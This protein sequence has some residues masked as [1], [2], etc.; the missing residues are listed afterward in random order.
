[1]KARSAD[2]QDEVQEMDDQ[3]HENPKE[4]KPQYIDKARGDDRQASAAPA[5][6]VSASTPAAAPPPDAGR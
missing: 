5:A 6:D 3:G 4:R 1:M 2:R